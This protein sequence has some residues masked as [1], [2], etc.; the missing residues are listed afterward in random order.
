MMAIMIRQIL[1]PFAILSQIRHLPIQK[2]TGL[3]VEDIADVMY[4]NQEKRW[5]YSDSHGP[6]FWMEVFGKEVVN[7]LD[8][9]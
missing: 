3:W 7:S 5:R 4:K 8:K 9:S 6:P 1:T 2:V